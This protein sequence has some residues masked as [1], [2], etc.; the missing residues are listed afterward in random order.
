[1]RTEERVMGV[2]EEVGSL[3][4]CHGDWVV[5][6]TEGGGGGSEG[7]SGNGLRGQVFLEQQ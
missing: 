4:P 3:R 5:M 6:A 2:K 1:M 7:E